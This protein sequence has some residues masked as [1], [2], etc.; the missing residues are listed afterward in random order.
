[1]EKII[2]NGIIGIFDLLGY[3]NF[4]S[5]NSIN[6][7]ARDIKSIIIELPNMVKKR[8]LEFYDDNHS[9]PNSLKS[10][11]DSFLEKNLHYII[12][13]DTILLAFDFQELMSED[14]DF[15]TYIAL[16]YITCFQETSF[17]KGF[18]MRGCVDIGEFYFYDNTFAGNTIVNSFNESD[19]LNF[20]GTII[21][22]NAIKILKEK[23]TKSIDAFIEFF[24]EKYK[25]P[26]KDDVEEYKYIIGC[27]IDIRDW[28]KDDLRQIIFE[29]FHAHKKEIDLSVIE[30]IN[31]T[32][33]I[34]RL[35]LM[36]RKGGYF[37]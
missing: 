25:V 7:C 29:S 13:S 5:N 11:I 16:Y 33:N 26:L 21:T 20:S 28:E 10:Q 15:F 35:F 1:M 36:K 18:P 19:M 6:D 3:K 17:D 30:K 8:I 2:E 34:V 24:V 9:D 23:H 22:A 32:E 31:N 14:A 4:V 37:A 27:P 12:V